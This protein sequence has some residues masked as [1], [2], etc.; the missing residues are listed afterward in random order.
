MPLRRV[1]YMRWAKALPRRRYALAGSGVTPPGPAFFD[2]AA[3]EVR[4]DQDDAYGIEPLI[5]AIADGYGV[6]RDHVLP[7]PGASLANFIA[8]GCTVRRGERVLLEQPV[9]EPLCRVVEFLELEIVPI[10]REPERRYRVD[11]DAVRAG[12]SGG[13]KAVLMTDLHN[14]TGLRCPDDDLRELA[15]LTAGYGAWLI[16]DEV[17]RDYAV[18]NG[19]AG[20][21]SAASLG[22]HVVATG[23]LTKV[24]GLGGLRAGW[25]LACPGTLERARDLLDHLCVVNPLPSQ[26][27]AVAA[28][29]RLDDLAGRTR[30]VYQAGYPVYRRWLDSRDDVIG[31]GNDGALFEFPR[32]AGVEDTRPLCRLLAE[33]YDTSIVPGAFFGAPEHVRIGFVPAPELLS[34]GLERIGQAVERVRESRHSRS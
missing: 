32:I 3:A 15:E 31:F 23:S 20:R 10:R 19:K 5:A 18:I 30:E 24:Y 33:E 4:L 7:V 34:E 17:Y 16:V 27:M 6:G 8:V 26:Q 14:P 9:Y 28:L 2:P 25:L 29:R 12:L 13:A 11:L 22:D 21:A 1:E